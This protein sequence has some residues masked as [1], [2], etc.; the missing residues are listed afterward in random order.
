MN[1]SKEPSRE[2]G[3]Q[4]IRRQGHPHHM[5][6]LLH[7]GGAKVDGHGVEDGLAGAHDH[8]GNEADA[9]VRA[10]LGQQFFQQAQRCGA[11]EWPEQ[12]EGGGFRR[13]HTPC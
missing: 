7:T 12:D 10:K 4:H 8:R 9:A 13:A 5:G 1:A 3:G 11:A 2:H 6:Q